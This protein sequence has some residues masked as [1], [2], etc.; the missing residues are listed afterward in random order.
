LGVNTKGGT[1]F[2][3]IAKVLRHL[4]TYRDWLPGWK[5]VKSNRDRRIDEGVG[6]RNLD[7]T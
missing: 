5:A 1:G 4:G 2:P 6:R 3:G 7:A